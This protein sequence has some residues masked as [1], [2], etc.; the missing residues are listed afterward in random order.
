MAPV[1]N[2]TMLMHVSKRIRKRFQTRVLKDRG[3]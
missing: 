3:T 1:A 2:V